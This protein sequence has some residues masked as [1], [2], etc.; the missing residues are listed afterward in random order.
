MAALD[1]PESADDMHYYRANEHLRETCA[2][3]VASVVTEFLSHVFEIREDAIKL[4]QKASD[5]SIG[6][7]G[8]TAYHDMSTLEDEY[9]KYHKYLIEARKSLLNQSPGDFGLL[10]MSINWH[11]NRWEMFS[12]EI[13]SQIDLAFDELERTRT[14]I[15]FMRKLPR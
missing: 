15:T 12:D 6:L 13:V 3:G 4:R 14:L 10:E 11:M 9:Q 8:Y 1:P 7:T 2:E 5:V